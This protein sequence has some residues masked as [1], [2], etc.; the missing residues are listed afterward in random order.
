MDYKAKYLKYKN[1]YLNLYNLNIQLQI[2]GGEVETQLAAVGFNERKIKEIKKLNGNLQKGKIKIAYEL[3]KGGFTEESAVRYAETGKI[4]DAQIKTAIYLLTNPKF[5]ELSALNLAMKY[6][7]EINEQQIKN[8]N[9]LIGKNYD[10]ANSYKL[11]LEL[12][13]LQLKNYLDLK[14]SGFSE[15][16][17]LA[18]T[19][20]L[21]DDKIKNAIDLK[22]A[23]VSES[24]SVNG[25]KLLTGEKIKTAIYLKKNGLYDINAIYFPLNF[26]ELKLKTFLS[27]IDEIKKSQEPKMLLETFDHLTDAQIIITNQ[28]I[29]GGFSKQNGIIGSSR[30]PGDTKKIQEKVQNAIELF[31]AGYDQGLAFEAGAIILSIDKDKENIKKAIEYLKTG[32]NRDILKRMLERIGTSTES[33][34]INMIELKKLGFNDKDCEDLAKLSSGSVNK[35]ELKKNLEFISNLE[36]N[37]FSKTTA[38]KMI[39]VKKQFDFPGGK[40][41]QRIEDAVYLK[42]HFKLSEDDCFTIVTELDYVNDNQFKTFENLYPIMAA[43]RNHEKIKNPV[44]FAY[45]WAKQL[46]PGKKDG[47]KERLARL[48]KEYST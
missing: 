37:G 47:H 7:G 28:L 30:L 10:M 11:A 27:L 18:I 19:N 48:I 25:A 42:Q 14:E 17:S 21:T 45:Q 31:K 15:R 20:E 3:K 1:K 13:D 44:D 33:R 38:I 36:K 29:D 16:F 9:D 39:Y 40:Y 41:D 24:E 26:S 2:A 5:D 46:Y 43:E 8:A 12:T 23:G 6:N 22:K 35:G 32:I 34:N 4:N